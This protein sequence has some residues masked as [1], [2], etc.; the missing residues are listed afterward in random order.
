MTK[1][2][3]CIDC[4]ARQDDKGVCAACGRGDTLDTREEKVRELMYDVDLRLRQ[5]AETRARMIG[6]ASTEREPVRIIRAG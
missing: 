2:W 6:V 1:A 4:G 5:K 3:V